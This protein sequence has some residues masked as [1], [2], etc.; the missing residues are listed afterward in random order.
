V[1]CACDAGICSARKILGGNAD[2]CE[3]KRVAEKAIRNVVKTKA[4]KIDSPRKPVA[5]VGKR[6]DET[7]ARSA[8]P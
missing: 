3:N 7:G 6:K 1:F 2:D 8:E 5:G 4:I